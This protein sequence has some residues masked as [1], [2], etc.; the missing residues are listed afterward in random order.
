M[1]RSLL[2]QSSS[3]T[4]PAELR[5]LVLSFFRSLPRGQVLTLRALRGCLP[6]LLRALS[7]GHL[8]SPKPQK[9]L[10]APVL[11]SERNLRLA[12]P[13]LAWTWSSQGSGAAG[14]RS[15]EAPAT[16]ELQEDREELPAL[17]TTLT[18]QRS[19]TLHGLGKMG[20]TRRFRIRARPY[21]E[22]TWSAWSEWCVVDAGPP[23]LVKVDVF[24]EAL[25]QPIT[26]WERCQPQVGLLTLLP[27]ETVWLPSDM[28]MG[29]VAVAASEVIGCAE[30]SPEDEMLGRPTSESPTARR[31][32]ASGE[33]PS[34]ETACFV[35]VHDGN[36]LRV[37]GQGIQEMSFS[38][39][40]PAH[41]GEELYVAVTGAQGLGEIHLLTFTKDGLLQEGP[42]V[43]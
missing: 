38:H 4:D 19:V 17:T 24:S 6:L 29:Q 43:T 15:A 36:L 2:S 8:L 23:C 13:E 21:Y 26:G 3:P 16:F 11:R 42:V 9:E 10:E 27:L 35:I 37:H 14:P 31:A 22:A 7:L 30:P 20:G 32:V 41:S 33:P 39:F 28:T 12:L 25:P 40:Q 34:P 5:E 1:A 18:K